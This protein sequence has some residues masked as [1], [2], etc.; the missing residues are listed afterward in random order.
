MP[1]IENAE[2]KVVRTITLLVNVPSDF[3]LLAIT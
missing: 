2:N 1:V 3:M